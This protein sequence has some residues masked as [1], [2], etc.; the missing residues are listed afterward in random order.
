M[1]DIHVGA[2]RDLVP[3]AFA[4]LAATGAALGCGVALI[5]ELG[6]VRHLDQ[7]GCALLAV[8]ATD[9]IDL[10]PKRRALTV[11]APM[12]ARCLPSASRSCGPSDR[13]NR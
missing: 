11:L 8:N 3:H 1:T 2:P 5:D 6:V 4:A 12:A 7:R 9:V 13:G 10:P